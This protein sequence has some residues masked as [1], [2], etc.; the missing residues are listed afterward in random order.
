M[1]PLKLI[2]IVEVPSALNVRPLEA[3]F[4]STISFSEVD[5]PNKD[6]IYTEKIR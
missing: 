5:L 2:Q 6:L 4:I 1:L 3:P